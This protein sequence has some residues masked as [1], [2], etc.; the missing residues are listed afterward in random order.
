MLLHASSLIT[1]LLL[2]L[3][4]KAYFKERHLELESNTVKPRLRILIA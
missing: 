4:Y 1:L 3:L 2:L